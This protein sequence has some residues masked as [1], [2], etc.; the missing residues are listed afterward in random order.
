MQDFLKEM[1]AFE[2]EA[3]QALLRITTEEELEQLRVQF[4]GRKSAFTQALAGLKR[5]SVSERKRS[6]P[7]SKHREGGYRR[8]V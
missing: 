2:A 1:Q 8:S 3:K 5:F 7:G 4:L 6:G